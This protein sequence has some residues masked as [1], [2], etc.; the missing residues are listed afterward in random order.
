M[1]TFL[2]QKKLSDKWMKATV[3]GSYWAFVEIVAGSFL[4]NLKIPMAGSILS[5]ITVF[6]VIAFFQLW[7]TNGIIWRAGLICAL[8]RSISPGSILIGPMIGIC[9]EAIILEVTIWILGKNIISYASG[10]ALVLFSAIIHKAISLLILYGLDFVLLIK[11]MYIFAA[12]QIGLKNI[13]P[14]EL[15]MLISGIYLFSGTL[16]GIFGTMAGRNH[17]KNLNLDIEIPKI[18]RKVRSDLFEK[19]QKSNQSI[20]F[21]SFILIALIGSMIIINS[22][23]IFIPVFLSFAFLTIIKV[24]YNR[25]M[26]FLSRPLIWFQLILILVFSAL[27]YEGFSFNNIFNSDGWIIGI[28]MV[29]RALLLLSAFSA[30]SY[31]LKNPIIRKILYDRGLNNLYLS[32]E[33]AFSGLPLLMETFSNKKNKQL[34]FKNILN[35]MLA[36]S[37]T[38]FEIYSSLEKN[39]PVVFI[40]SGDVNHGKTST[41]KNIVTDLLCSGIKV[42]GFYSV[43]STDENGHKKYDVE[44]IDTGKKEM[45]C[46][47]I[48]FDTK[49]KTGKFYFSEKGIEYGCSII[50][51]SLEEDSDLI[52]IDEIG[53]L[54]VQDKGWSPVIETFL[55]KNVP[56]QLWVIREKLV[57]VI[58]RKWSLG[59]T[60]IFDIK[61]EPILN[62]SGTI[63]EILSTGLKIDA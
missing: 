17:L 55:L 16:A 4:H 41:T 47:D 11:N 63:R 24:R 32:M 49:S 39:K 1:T 15:L 48:Q 25:N 38:L 36:N 33:L 12:S 37:G 54:E 34:R 60:Y 8:M 26:K 28:K 23:E 58:I 59:D 53:P 57:P 10:G 52:V 3:L 22:D 19:N 40:I 46:T 9:S 30:I 31:E 50:K 56:F 2:P 29:L 21:L 20:L 14:F 35:S 43:G 5:F 18:E 51:K 44:D 61:K 7:K 42:K 62:I 13:S 27:F 45:L 6:L